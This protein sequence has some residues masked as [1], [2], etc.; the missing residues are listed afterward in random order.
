MI[1]DNE[2]FDLKEVEYVAK[3][4]SLCV[5][6]QANTANAYKKAKE[7]KVKEKEVKNEEKPDLR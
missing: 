3:S 7:K 2:N 5:A 4:M 1:W 6:C